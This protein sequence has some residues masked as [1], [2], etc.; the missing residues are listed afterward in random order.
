MFGLN[1]LFTLRPICPNRHFQLCPLWRCL[2]GRGLCGAKGFG[3]VH[4]QVAFCDHFV[5]LG[6]LFLAFSYDLVRILKFFETIV[7]CDITFVLNVETTLHFFLQYGEECLH[8]QGRCGKS[9]P[10]AAVAQW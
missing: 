2:H 9:R 4:Q 10:I 7:Q 3:A 8:N 1:Q 6:W 5:H